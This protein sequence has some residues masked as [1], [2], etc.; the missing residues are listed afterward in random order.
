VITEGY[1]LAK[2]ECLKFLEGFKY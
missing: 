2:K 1:E